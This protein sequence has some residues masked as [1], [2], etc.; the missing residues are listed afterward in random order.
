M[1]CVDNLSYDDQLTINKIY[2]I[3]HEDSRYYRVIDDRNN[4]VTVFKYR[5][6]NINE[7]KIHE[8]W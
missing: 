6:V 5:F 4:E 7:T 1:K 2:T 8:L 3:L